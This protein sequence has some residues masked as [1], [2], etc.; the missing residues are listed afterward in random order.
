M[1]RTALYHSFL[2]D[3]ID[4]LVDECPGDL[5]D[6]MLDPRFSPS[7]HGFDCLVL[8]I[9]HTRNSE[10]YLQRW[11]DWIAEERFDSAGPRHYEPSYMYGYLQDLP[12]D[13]SFRAV[14]D[15]AHAHIVHL[16]RS[17]EKVARAWHNLEG[18][19]KTGYAAADEVV[20][21]IKRSGLKKDQLGS[22]VLRYPLSALW[23]LSRDPT[24]QS[25]EFEAAMRLVEQNRPE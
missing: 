18:L 11:I 13:A 22:D 14:R 2:R 17:P 12:D 15:A 6:F 3:N 21:A 7:G 23:A 24:G 5:A 16:L 25:K 19:L 9:K 8:A 20:T 4:E 1:D 10:P